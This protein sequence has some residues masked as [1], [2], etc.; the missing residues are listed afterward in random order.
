MVVHFLLTGGGV[1]LVG[2]FFM[3][4]K[5]LLLMGIEPFRLSSYVS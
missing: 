3:F 1:G 4:L 5:G 2:D